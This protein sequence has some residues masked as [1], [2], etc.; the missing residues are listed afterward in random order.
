M[1]PNKDTAWPRNDLWEAN[2]L[3]SRSRVAPVKATTIPRLELCALE[4][5][6]QLVARLREL[7]MLVNA[8]YSYWT[9]SEMVL[10][11]LRKRPDTLKF[12]VANRVSN[13]SD[14]TNIAEIRHVLS[15]R[16]RLTCSHE[17]HM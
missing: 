5:I 9:D 1:L 15:V 3:C 14:I 17:E 11:W 6:T 8:T 10:K 13:I 4:L 12:Y 7:P 16:T 2:L